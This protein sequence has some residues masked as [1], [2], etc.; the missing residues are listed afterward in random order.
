MKRRTDLDNLTPDQLQW[1]VDTLEL[2]GQVLG[3]RKEELEKLA[4]EGPQALMLL[5][6]TN[7]N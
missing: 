1:L 3:L 2:I 4:R 5:F 6:H 7:Q